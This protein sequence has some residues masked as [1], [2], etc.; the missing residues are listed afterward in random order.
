VIEATVED[1]G[2]TAETT[3]NATSM[4]KRMRFIP[5]RLNGAAVRTSVTIP[6]TVTTN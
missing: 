6:I 5:G 3:Q 1:V 2:L 4:A